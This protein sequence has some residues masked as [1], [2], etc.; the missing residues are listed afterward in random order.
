[1]PPR[2]PPPATSLLDPIL[3]AN[4]ARPLITY[5]D[6]A[7]GERIELSAT[8]FANWV[9]KSANLLADEC[10]AEPGSRIAVLLPTHWQTAAVLLAAWS[11]GAEVVGV[12]QGGDR[13]VGIEADLVACDVG[14]LGAALDLAPPSGVLAFSL[15]A[16]G[17]GL[18]ELPAGVLDFAT[19]V[20]LQGDVFV[21]P[22][23]VSADLPALDGRSGAEVL[24]EASAR[25]ET[26]GWSATD[27]VLSTLE[28]STP[29]GL[30]DGLLAVLAAG[31][32]LVHCAHPAGPEVLDRRFTS[33]K[34]TVR[35]V[36]ASARAVCGES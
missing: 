23:P 29:D 4:P 35:A 21:P 27:R 16:F 8:T 12:G 31:A 1:M 17:R 6:D 28:W 2:H 11:C 9:A 32:S 33:E 14:R 34:C 24:A 25:A 22:V 20:R 36:A 30:R 26:L 18:P 19:E 15:D 3:R 5:Y 13:Q 10:D 7:T